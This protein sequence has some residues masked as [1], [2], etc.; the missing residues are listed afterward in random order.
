MLNTV[1]L[2][3]KTILTHGFKEIN[4]IKTQ[5]DAPVGTFVSNAFTCT[6]CPIPCLQ[7]SDTEY[8]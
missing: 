8:M 1:Y 4:A 6:S 2:V 3:Q 5:L 7:C